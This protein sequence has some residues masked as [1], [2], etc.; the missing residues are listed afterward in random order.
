MIYL[1]VEDFF[2]LML[3]GS[4]MF[5]KNGAKLFFGSQKNEVFRELCAMQVCENLLK[6]DLNTEE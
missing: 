6:N 4:K 5:A 1:S 3:W 2:E